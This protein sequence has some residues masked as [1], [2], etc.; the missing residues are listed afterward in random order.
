M[1]EAV[2]KGWAQAFAGQA[3]QLG[4]ANERTAAAIGIFRRCETMVN[5]A[6]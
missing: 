1:W 5:A 4:K 2:A 6:R 3:G